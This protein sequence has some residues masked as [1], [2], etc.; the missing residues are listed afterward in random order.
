VK[1]LAGNDEAGEWS[2]RHPPGLPQDVGGPDK[3]GSFIVG[4]MPLYRVRRNAHVRQQTDG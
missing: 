4:R 2:A 1:N 3:A